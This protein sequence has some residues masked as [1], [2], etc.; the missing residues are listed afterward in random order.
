M[1]VSFFIFIQEATRRFRQIGAIAPSSRFLVKK[2]IEPV[3]FRH[4]NI[5]V[6]LGCGTGVITR[7]LLNRMKPETQ[8]WAFEINNEM[9]NFLKKIQDKRLHLIHDDALNFPHYLQK[10]RIQKVDYFI[11]SLPL[12]IFSTEQQRQLFQNIQQYLSRQGAYVQ[13]QYSLLS[14]KHIKAF[15]PSVRTYFTPLNLPPAVIYVAYKRRVCI[16]RVPSLLS[17]QHHKKR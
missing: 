5:I 8:L 15:F 11:S 14:L 9:L 1:S 7:A 4:A 12:A 6:E 16:K 3:D 2:M 10:A 13:F 17:D